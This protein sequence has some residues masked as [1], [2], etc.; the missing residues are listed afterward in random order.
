MGDAA[1]GERHVSDHDGVAVIQ[2]MAVEEV[3][4]HAKGAGRQEGFH[5]ANDP[6]SRRRL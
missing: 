3:T 4:E 2:L 1:A 6:A 5:R